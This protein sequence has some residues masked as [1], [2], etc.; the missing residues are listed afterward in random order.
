MLQARQ[1]NSLAFGFRVKQVRPYRLQSEANSWH[2]LENAELI[3]FVHRLF[4]EPNQK[5]D[6]TSVGWV[7]SEITLSADVTLLNCVGS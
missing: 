3:Q 4:H 5:F 1:L 2:T 6:R 7:R